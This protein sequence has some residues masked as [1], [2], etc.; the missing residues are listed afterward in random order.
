MKTIQITI[1]EPLLERLDEAATC[2]RIA[3][4]GLIRS[5]I[6][7]FLEDRELTELERRDEAAYREHPVDE[8]ELAPW[9]KV[10]AWED[11]DWSDV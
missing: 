9:L 7:Q 4:S 5:A 6:E 11:D 10:Q 3:R 1:D 2:E 8:D